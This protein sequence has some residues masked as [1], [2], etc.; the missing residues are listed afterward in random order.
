MIKFVIPPGDGN[1]KVPAESNYRM[2][3]LCSASSRTC[4]C[5]GRRSSTSLRSRVAEPETLLRVPNYNF[6]WQLTYRAGEAARIETRSEDWMWRD[7][8]TTRP[9][10]LLNPDPKSEVRWGEQS[11]EEM[12]IGFFDVAVPF[13][14]DQRSFFERSRPNRRLMRLVLLCALSSACA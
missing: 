6:N 3:A 10:T 14:M 4:T 2:A 7:G 9:T 12:M 8:S 13:D 1:Y 5:G 11:W